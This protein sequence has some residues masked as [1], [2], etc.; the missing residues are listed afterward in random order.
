MTILMENYHS[1]MVQTK[2]G[3]MLFFKNDDPIGECL[4]TYG[5]WAEQEFSVISKLVKENSNCIDIGAN[6]GTHSVWLSRHCFKGYTIS[7]EPQFYIFSLLSTNLMLNDCMNCLPIKAFVS[8]KEVDTINAA[9]FSPNVNK[10]NY[11][12]F[13]IN[14]IAND[15]IATPVIKL[16]NIHSFGKV[17]F[18]KMDC[19]GTEQ[20][21]LLSGHKLLTHDKPH[22]YLEYNGING[23]QSI[24]DTLHDYGYECYWH[25]YPKFNVE[26]HNKVPVNIYLELDKQDKA[27]TV[28]DASLLFEAN[29]ICIH[30]DKD[31]GMF[32][33]KIQD[34]DNMINWLLRN[35]WIS[36]E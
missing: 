18:I 31:E 23:N 33:D 24:I 13:S 14:S 35:N 8:N 6:L 25:V 2:Y 20:E 3:P 19:E 7:I 29:V 9:V 10:F 32:T 28:D 12:E 4:T 34:N 11:G 21:V 16:D 27:P 5:E 22:L 30:K 26:N 17:D 15:G 36:L 1:R